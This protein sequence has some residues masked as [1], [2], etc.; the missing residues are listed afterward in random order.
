MD[1]FRLFQEG[2]LF[3]A[4]PPPPVEAMDLAAPLDLC[5]KRRDRSPSTNRSS[6]GGT[7]CDALPTPPKLARNSAP[8]SLRAHHQVGN[9][10]KKQTW[11]PFS[12]WG[13][14]L[15]HSVLFLINFVLI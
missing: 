1:P 10:M 7:P 9:E 12:L 2:D 5:V 11:R 13:T 6:G 3:I 14:S 15:Q 4:P 8:P